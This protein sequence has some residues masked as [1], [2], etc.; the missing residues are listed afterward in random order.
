MPLLYNAD[1]ERFI[2]WLRWKHTVLP[3][4]VRDPI[5]WGL[6]ALHYTVLTKQQA[7]LAE[8]SSLPDLNWKASSL[9]W[10]L[11][12]FF[13]VFYGG[14]CYGRFYAFYGA[15]TG[16]GGAL[17]EWA[18]LIRSHF[19][20]APA[21]VK[22][23][24]LRLMLGAMELQLASLGG[25]NDAGGKGLDESEWRAIRMHGFFSYAEIATLQKYKGSKP[26]LPAVWALSEVRAALKAKLGKAVGA[27]TVSKPAESAP[28]SPTPGKRAEHEAEATL[29]MAP[30]AMAVYRDFEGTVLKF[31]GHCGASTNLLKMPVP[32]ACEAPPTRLQR[33]SS[34]PPTRASSAPPTAPAHRTP[35]PPLCHTSSSHTPWRQCMHQTPGRTFGVCTPHSG[36]APPLL[37]SSSGCRCAQTSTFSSS[38]S[39]SPSPSRRMLSSSLSTRR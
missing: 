14:H 2:F 20:G 11:L 33:A 12:T 7:L 19:E 18:Y 35:P 16:L 15:C 26:F 39:S 37:T 17:G 31:K 3:M 29:L 8:G 24:M 28:A 30:A 5:F 10:S 34:A 32:F 27:S 1:V 23:H 4:V 9:L 6:M 13:V 25:T 21:Q 22:W 36:A 38:S